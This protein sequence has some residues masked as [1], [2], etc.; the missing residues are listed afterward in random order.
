MRI[1]ISSLALMLLA[2]IAMGAGAA[3]VDASR[4]RNVATRYLQ[5]RADGRML[6]ASSHVDLTYTQ[7]SNADSRQADYYVFA[8]SDGIAFVIV[9]GDDRAESVLGYGKGSLDMSNVPCNL[10]SMLNGYKEQ[11]EWLIAHPQ[12]TVERSIPV[13]DVTIAP[14]LTCNWSQSEP[15]YNQCPIIQGERSVT[16]CVATAMAQVMYYWRYPAHAP[17]VSS[18]VTRSHRI[19]V[20]SLPGCDLDWDNMID[21]YAATPYSQEQAN[22]VATLMRYCGQSVRMD[23]SPLGSGAYVY[24]QL[25]GMKAFGYNPN[26][27]DLLKQNYSYDEWDALLQEELLAGR[28]ILY[29][30]NDPGAG[31][32]AF[33]LDGYYDG[34]Y[35]INWGWGGSYDGYFALGAFNVRSYSFL[36]N[37]EFLYGIYPPS[38]AQIDG[39][40]DFEVDGIYYRYGDRDGEAW[41]TCKDTRYNSYSGHVTVPERVAVDGKELTVTAIGECAF[42]DCAGLTGVVL[43]QTLTRI[44]DQAFR[45]C[46]SLADVVIPQHV[47]SLGQQTFANCLALSQITLPASVKHLAARAFVGC[48]SL[49][50]VYTPSLEDWLEISFADRDAN[51]LSIAHHLMVGGEELEHLV[52]PGNFESVGK[53]S[54]IECQGLKSVVLEDG[55][56]S[57]GA[58]AFANCTKLTSLA[59]PEAMSSLGSQAFIGCTGL[60]AVAVPEGIENL[61]SSL[62]SGCSR[63]VQVTLP[64]TL[65]GIGNSVFANCSALAGITIPDGV[66][67]IGEEAFK[68]CKGMKYVDFPEGLTAIGLSAFQ[69]CSSLSTVVIP[70]PV[71]VVESQTFYR[72]TGLTELTL[73]K[74]LSA[75][76]FKAFNECKNIT[77]VTS[78]NSVP[79]EVANPDCFARTIYSTATLRV[80]IAAL[81]VYRNTGIWPWF[82][83]MV[84]IDVDALPGD[85][86]GDGEANIADVNAVIDAILR[87]MGD[88]THDVNGDGEVNIGDVNAIIDII[89]N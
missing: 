66:L 46:V 71:E 75:I 60:T 51:P 58:S 2:T 39:M 65:T 14:L 49:T 69:D 64:A 28:P 7:V 87:G 86:N 78:R 88:S 55:V 33:V 45:S 16:G 68:S 3:P 63:L 27:Q 85:V 36:A 61:P 12:A 59:L 32:H 41:V 89:L 29:S 25:S 37:Q 57:V 21:D 67:S 13:N 48:E 24:Q 54:F 5:S 76:N 81:S 83:N 73:G 17:S 10:Q 53:Y 11:M 22:A 4:A 40:C 19:S 82:K 44:G 23:Y 42:R 79:P 50:A 15:F 56:R 6:R 20:P 43:P 62:F 52:V 9:A 8:T 31:G 34:K 70:D 80:P 84:G 35:H 74:S 47:A 26:A 77:R 1:S 30:A 72:C 38:Q 18:Y